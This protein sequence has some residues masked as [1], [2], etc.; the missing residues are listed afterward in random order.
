MRPA[1][2]TPRQSAP[3]PGLWGDTDHSADT[4]RTLHE[5]H[6][7][8]GSIPDGPTLHALPAPFP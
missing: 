1:C 2:G 8:A 3:Q 5:P 7:A 6:R 4:E